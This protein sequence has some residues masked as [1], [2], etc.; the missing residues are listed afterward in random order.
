MFHKIISKVRKSIGYLTKTTQERRHS[1]VG[2][3]SVWKYTRDFQFQF[4]LD[5][6]LQ[7]TDTLMDIGCGTLRGGIPLIKY[8]DNGNYY[9]IDVREN[10]LIEG[11]K[12]IKTANLESKKPNLIAF[13]DFSE[14]KIDHEFN[15]MFAFSVL[16]HFDDKIAENC[17]EF[18]SKSLAKGG[19]FYA[20]V[21]IATHENGKWDR[22][23]IVF[24]SQDFYKNLANKNGLEVEVMGSLLELGH[25][26]GRKSDRQQ[27]MFKF[28]KV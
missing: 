9:G 24:R 4:L 11:G 7:K 22:F 12:E 10:V 18:V 1:L 2:N 28:F 19:V 26:T 25:D 23:P 27:I 14:I 20:N 6:G 5:Q 15:I 17:F 16:I 13:E 21:N 8:L 3:P